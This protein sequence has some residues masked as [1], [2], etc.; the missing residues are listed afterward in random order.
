[1]KILTVEE[2]AKRISI[3]AQTLRCGLRAGKYPFGVAFK[4]K[5]AN[6]KYCYQIFEPHLEKWEKGEL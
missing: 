3:P 5:E 4:T 1:M 6:K 2:A